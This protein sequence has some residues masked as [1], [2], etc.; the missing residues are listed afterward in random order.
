M[1]ERHFIEL[2]DTSRPPTDGLLRFRILYFRRVYVLSLVSIDYGQFL[3]PIDVLE[4]KLFLFIYI[5]SDRHIGNIIYV[6]ECPALINVGASR[7]KCFSVL[8][9]MG[10]GNLF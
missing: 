10:M 2:C 6:I 4:I 3:E 5:I 9:Y 1:S 8:E 7:L